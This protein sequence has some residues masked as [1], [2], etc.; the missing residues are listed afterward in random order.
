MAGRARMA[1][2]G[3]VEWTE[4]AAVDRV[5]RSGEVAH[6]GEPFSEPAGG[7]AVVAVQMAR[8]GAESVF[9]TALGRDGHGQRSKQRLEQL[10]VRVHVAWRE[11]PTRRALTL[12]DEDG[13]RTIITLGARLAPALDDDLPWDELADTDGVY[14]TAGDCGA[15]RAARQARVLVATPRARSALRAGVA[16]DALVLSESDPDERREAEALSQA[17]ALLVHTEGARGGSY[18]RSDGGSGRWCAAAL[19]GPRGD[20][21]GCGDSFAAG[22]TFGLATGLD[23]DDAVELA[24]RCGAACLTGHGPYGHQLT[25]AEL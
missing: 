15:L 18:R 17:P 1:T 13:E 25:A 22:F 14:F 19:P 12:V 4:Y 6:A 7:G 9:F 8:L 2:I 20:S 24:A 11:E 23:A 10:G 16:L 21:Y 3:H 5:P